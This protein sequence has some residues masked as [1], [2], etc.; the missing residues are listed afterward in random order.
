MIR[1]NPD[2][3]VLDF[4]LSY[5]AITKGTQTPLALQPQDI[6]YVPTSKAKAIFSSTQVIIGQA[7]AS[8][9]ITHP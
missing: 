5:D 2:G 3:T 6:V 8:A 4:P 1:R 7:A 9:I